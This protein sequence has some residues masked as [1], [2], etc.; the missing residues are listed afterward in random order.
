MSTLAAKPEDISNLLVMDQEYA[1]PGIVG[2]NTIQKDWLGEC[3]RARKNPEQFWAD[4]AGRFS[5]TRKWNQVLE[6][7]GIHHRWFTGGK[8]NICLLYTS[9]RASP[10]EMRSSG[11]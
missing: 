4:Y 11:P 3:E 8:T 9:M 2:S 5:W 7:D 6:W 10:S 1:A